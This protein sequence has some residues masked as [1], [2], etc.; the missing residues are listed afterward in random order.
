MSRNNSVRTTDDRAE[1]GERKE[2]KEAGLDL[3]GRR[4]VRLL[5]CHGRERV[6]ESEPRARAAR[7]KNRSAFHRL[8]RTYRVRRPRSMVILLTFP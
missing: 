2:E 6:R 3:H 5:P 7:W 8:H 4:E 1:A